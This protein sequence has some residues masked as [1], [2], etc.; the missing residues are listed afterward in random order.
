MP[1]LEFGLRWTA[2]RAS[3]QDSV[4]LPSPLAFAE[5]NWRSERLRINF[6]IEFFF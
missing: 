3:S 6:M 4:A 5:N 1:P 2:E